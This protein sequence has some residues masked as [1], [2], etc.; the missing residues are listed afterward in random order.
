MFACLGDLYYTETGLKEGLKEG[1]P[2][3]RFLISK[4]GLPFAG[5]LT[6]AFV[7]SVGTLLAHFGTL[8]SL[9]FSLPIACVETYNTIRNYKLLPKK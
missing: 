2:V 3:A 8:A 5:F 4:L 7:I 6:T 1:M 9:A